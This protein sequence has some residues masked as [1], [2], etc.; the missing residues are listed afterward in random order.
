MI[1]F[2]VG[3]IEN[4][5]LN[6]TFHDVLGLIVAFLIFI[7]LLTITIMLKNTILKLLF[8]LI[9]IGFLVASP[10]LVKDTIDSTLRAVDLNIT[11]EKRLVFTDTLVIS[12]SL[13]NKGLIDYSKCSIY[14]RVVPKDTNEYLKPIFLY[15]KP[16]YYSKDKLDISYLKMNETVDFKVAINNFT[17]KSNYESVVAGECF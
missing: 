14:T 16:L 10:F 3:N 11:S 1:E 8:F 2:I 15:I 6:F 7:L 13:T 9:T 4:F 12:G 17:T 5:F